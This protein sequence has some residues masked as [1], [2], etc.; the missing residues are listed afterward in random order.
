MKRLAA[1]SLLCCLLLASATGCTLTN[2]RLRR[3]VVNQAGTLTELQYQQVLGNLAMMSLDPDA[4]PTHVTLRDGSAQIQDNGSISSASPSNIYPSVL[5]SRTVVEQWTLIPITDDVELRIL[6]LAYRRALGYD[7]KP[8]IDLVNDLAHDLCKQISNDDNIDLRSDPAVN[9][10]VL[11]G[12]RLF[13][14]LKN[15]DPRERD[16][17][18]YL[19]ALEEAYYFKA[20]DAF[21]PSL[22][23]LNILANAF[24]QL[25]INAND[26]RLIFKDEIEPELSMDIGTYPKN[27][28]GKLYPL[29]ASPTVRDARRQVK[30]F[31]D[32][33]AKIRGGWFGV[34]PKRAVPNDA[35]YVGHYRGQYAWVC[36]GGRKELA[37]FSLKVLDFATLIK[38]P[39]ITSVPG[40]PRYSPASVR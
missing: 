10:A 4:F 27:F 15:V 5:G 35:S 21:E 28:E 40:G 32:D 26:E 39:T 14:D 2:W 25:S 9:I 36:A 19:E 38:D 31:Y 23:R 18:N 30:Q 16:V 17:H 8:D 20:V 22:S 11:K 33:V 7:E 13:D 29:T 34:G 24:R 3:S 37:D 1:T 12:A 6:R